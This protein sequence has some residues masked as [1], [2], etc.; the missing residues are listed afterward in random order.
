ML[1]IP[2]VS[3]AGHCVKYSGKLPRVVSARACKRQAGS[4]CRGIWP[5]DAQP[6]S[7]QAPCTVVLASSG[8]LFGLVVPFL[9]DVG[10]NFDVIRQV[11]YRCMASAMHVCPHVVGNPLPNA[12][13]GHQVSY[14]VHGLKAAAPGPAA[15]GN[16]LTGHCRTLSR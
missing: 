16:I 9:A 4:T 5:C 6:G 14:A 1:R 11:I 2:D 12:I 13:G 15:E 7:A 3:Q 10:F 8:C